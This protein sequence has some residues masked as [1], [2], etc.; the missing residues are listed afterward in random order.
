MSCAFISKALEGTIYK[1]QM[2]IYIYIL[3]N[4]F[5]GKQYVGV[6][7]NPKIRLKEHYKTDYP[8]GRTLR[9]YDG[10]IDFSIVA[11]TND[12]KSAFELEKFYIKD[13][14]T[15]KPNGYNLTLGGEGNNT[16]RSVETKTKMGIA[17]RKRRD[18]ELNAK[19]KKAQGYFM[20]YFPIPEEE[21]SHVQ[22]KT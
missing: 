2:K 15:M 4:E 11:Q 22:K 17:Q 13:L 3:T 10:Q 6:S 18:K 7:K 16:P 5:N 21:K 20:N 9:K 1:R 12:Y 8:I 14:N 19:P